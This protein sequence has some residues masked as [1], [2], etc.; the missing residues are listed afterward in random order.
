MTEINQILLINIGLNLQYVEKLEHTEVLYIRII[1]PN[2]GI[3]EGDGYVTVS[4][5]CTTDRR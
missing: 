1:A 3:W 5:S 2:D 4:Q